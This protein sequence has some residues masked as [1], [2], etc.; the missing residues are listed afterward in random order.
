M[1]GSWIVNRERV[2]L[3]AA[4][5]PGTWSLV[6]QRIVLVACL[7]SPSCSNAVKL[8]SLHEFSTPR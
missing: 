7:H 6:L 2:Y 8:H 5:F 1:C 4:F 3:K